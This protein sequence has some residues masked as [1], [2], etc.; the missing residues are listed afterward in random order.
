MR[1][2]HTYNP[3]PP[4]TPARHASNCKSMRGFTLVELSV[5][6]AI[7]SIIMLGIGSTTLITTHA[8]PNE[9]NS[10]LA[11]LD[12]HPHLD[13]WAADLRVSRHIHTADIHE[14]EFTVADR[15]GDGVEDVIVYRWSGDAGDP[16]TR[17]YNGGPSAAVFPEVQFF[18]LQY[19]E[20]RIPLD[21]PSNDKVDV[22][23]AVH[24]T[25]GLSALPTGSMN[26]TVYLLNEPTQP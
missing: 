20:K 10:P 11:M 14:I 24:I 12:H 26:T 2:Q 5:S 6:M 13:I 19:T 22:I 8:M 1:T 15:D 7:M 18:S 21:H 17:T 16:V 9:T 25:L 3:S 4:F 23:S